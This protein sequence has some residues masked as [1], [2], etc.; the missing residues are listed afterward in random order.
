MHLSTFPFIGSR[1]LKNEWRHWV[2]RLRISNFSV[3]VPFQSIL[4]RI[5]YIICTIQQRSHKTWDKI[6]VNHVDNMK[7]RIDLY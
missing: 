5:F 2:L 7:E 4:H 6:V 3:T 1:L